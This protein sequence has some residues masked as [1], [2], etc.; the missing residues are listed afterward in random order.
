MAG[1][2]SVETCG[3]VFA[4]VSRQASSNYAVDSRGRVGMYVKECNR[5]WCSSSPA[6]DHRAITIEVANDEIGGNWH[7]SDIALQKTIDL[8]A[9]ICQRNGIQRL[10]YTG[11]TRGNLTKH[12]WFANTNCPGPYLG[13]KFSYIADKVNKQ[14]NSSNP[15]KAR[16]LYRVR[17]SWQDAISQKGAF[18]QL[19]NAKK[20]AEQHSGYFVF[21]DMGNIVYPIVSKPLDYLDT[22]AQ[23]V[24]NGD[25]GNGQD[26]VSRLTQAGYDYHE[27]QQKV[28]E[29]VSGNVKVPIKSIE[30]IAK[31][32]INGV[33]GNGV[34]RRNRLT[35]AGYDYD[36]VQQKVNE[37]LH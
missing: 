18:K 15:P 30:I 5:S 10:N 14:L 25:W 22:I 34:D 32:V 6:N 12:E 4:S 36:Q 21:D 29:L 2:L 13:G 28:N 35:Q 37:L 1:N 16:G 7:V 19:N 8:C 26:R 27:V 11:D 33:W 24:L 23:Q 31:E 20:C 9:G 17:Q 3:N